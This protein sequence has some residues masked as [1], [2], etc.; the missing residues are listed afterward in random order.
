MG[1]NLVARA[2]NFTI[3]EAEFRRLSSQQ[4]V[5]TGT[6]PIVNGSVEDGCITEG[7]HR[8]LK[9]NFYTLNQGNTDL[10]I[11]DPASHQDI[12]EKSTIH[13]SGWI[14]KE[15]FNQYY[16][17]NNSGSEVAS[18]FK[19]SWCLQDNTPKFNCRFQ[20]ISAG[21][22]D[23]YSSDL[24]CQFIKIDG[25]PDGEYTLEGTT[26]VSRSFQED[27]YD[28]NNTTVRLRIKGRIVRPITPTTKG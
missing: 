18:G 4:P 6:I 9:F 3:Q 28:D 5:P 20:G 1:V 7:R 25:L 12:Y 21:S 10:V 11:G 24:S 13:A 16:L 2:T 14:T 17:K 26:N 8:I 15:K 19:R 22:F 23:T 27:T